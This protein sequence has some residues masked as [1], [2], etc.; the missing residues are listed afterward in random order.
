MS[1]NLHHLK[2]F[3][4]YFMTVETIE[5]LLTVSKSC[6]SDIGYDINLYNVREALAEIKIRNLLIHTTRESGGIEIFSLRPRQPTDAEII[7]GD[8]SCKMLFCNRGIFK[9]GWD[10]S[11]IG[12]LW[13][14]EHLNRLDK[15]H[16]IW[17]EFGSSKN[18]PH[19]LR[20]PLLITMRR[21]VV[22]K[23]KKVGCWSWLHH[24]CGYVSDSESWDVA[25]S[26]LRI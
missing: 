10:K 24:N 9:R 18:F 20:D 17:R 13:D 14:L 19:R 26:G 3:S 7:F 15:L 23:P 25:Q 1:S 6:H 12:W 5:D 2:F 4:P 11:R 22:E 16:H 21:T 8:C